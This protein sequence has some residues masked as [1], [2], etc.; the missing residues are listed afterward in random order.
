[1]SVADQ[2]R[3]RKGYWLVHVTVRDADAY[4]GYVEQV[5]PVVDR[6]GGR[7]LVRGGVA[8]AP[9]GPVRERHVVVEFDSYD[10]ALAAYRDEDYQV[11]AAIRRDHS[12]GE[13]VIVEGA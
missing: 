7:F 12:E 9:E 11:A 3:G 2:A 13:F 8:T 1:M 5:T 4:G 6:Y 10:T